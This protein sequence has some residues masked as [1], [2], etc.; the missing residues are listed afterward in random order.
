MWRVGADDV[1]PARLI[2]SQQALLLEP[3][4]SRQRHAI[5][6]AVIYESAVSASA[7][8][9]PPAKFRLDA[10]GRPSTGSGVQGRGDGGPG[11]PRRLMLRRLV[12][13]RWYDAAGTGYPCETREDLAEL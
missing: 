7:S 6:H 1:W 8:P 9:F 12:Y 4:G 2:V 5:L 3:D 10:S 13:R 11:G